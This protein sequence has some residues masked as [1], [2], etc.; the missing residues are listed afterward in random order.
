MIFNNKRSESEVIYDILSAAQEDIKKTR[1]MYKANMTHTQFTKY[2]DA[3][4]EKDILGEKDAYP[5]GKNYYV[6]DKGKEL[7]ELLDVVLTS[8][9]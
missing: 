4:L 9:K 7:H 8:L 6:T 5:T 2:L 1:L 3:L